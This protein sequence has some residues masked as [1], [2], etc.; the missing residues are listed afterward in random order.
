MGVGPSSGGMVTLPGATPVKKTEHSSPTGHHLSITL[1]LA[2]QAGGPLPIA[3]ILECWLVG[4]CA[5]IAG[6]RSSSEFTKAE[7]LPCP[8]DT[9]LLISS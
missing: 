5:G 9:V 4:S 6:I 7:V 3:T 1:Q 8:E 2:V